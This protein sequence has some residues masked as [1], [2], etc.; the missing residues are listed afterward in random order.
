MQRA[1]RPADGRREQPASGVAEVDGLRDL[2][3]L[4][5]AGFGTNGHR[6]LLPRRLAPSLPLARRRGK[7]A[8]DGPREVGAVVGLD[9]EGDPC[10][11]RSA[12]K[13]PS[14]AGSRAAGGTTRWSPRWSSAPRSS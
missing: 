4:E 6:G 1:A 3:L 10:P 8:P 12:N 13:P 14:P 11:W 5:P 7:R 9:A 2:P